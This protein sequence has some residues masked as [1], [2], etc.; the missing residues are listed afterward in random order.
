M[1]ASFKTDAIDCAIDLGSAEDLIAGLSIVLR[2][3]QF[4]GLVG[5]LFLGVSTNHI[6]LVETMS[7]KWDQFWRNVLSARRNSS[8]ECIKAAMHLVV[9]QGMSKES[10]PRYRSRLNIIGCFALLHAI[11]SVKT[12]KASSIRQG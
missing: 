1:P 11:K 9:M 6:T 12:K 8:G 2:F 7:W 3:G 5:G 10:R 4:G